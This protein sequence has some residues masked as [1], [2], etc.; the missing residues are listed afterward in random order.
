MG[1][2]EGANV[3]SRISQG[4]TLADPVRDRRFRTALRRRECATTWTDLPIATS[5]DSLE[6]GM[7]WAIRPRATVAHSCPGREK[8]DLDGHRS[9]SERPSCKAFFPAGRRARR[10]FNLDSEVAEHRAQIDPVCSL[11]RPPQSSPDPARRGR[12]DR[13][14]L[15]VAKPPTVT[16]FRRS[17]LRFRGRPRCSKASFS[18]LALSRNRGAAGRMRTSAHVVDDADRLPHAQEFCTARVG[19]LRVK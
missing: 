9:E 17:A 12:C 2:I 14:R 8:R 13:P 1:P 18:S 16:R 3:Q 15:G 6:H 10:E 19:V 4:T 7:L 5:R 11:A